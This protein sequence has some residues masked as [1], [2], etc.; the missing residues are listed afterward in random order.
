MAFAM[1][2]IGACPY[3]LKI[4]IP[5][6]ALAEETKD[7]R[8]AIVF[9]DMWDDVCPEFSKSRFQKVILITAADGM[10]SPKRQIVSLIGKIK[11]IRK[12]APKPVGG[13][14]LHLN[15][16]R[17]HAKFYGENVK[18]SFNP[19]RGAFITSSSGTTVGGIVKGTIATNES[20]ISQLMM[21]EASD[22]PYYPGDTCLDPYPPTA[23]TALNLMFLFPLYKGMTVIMDPR[24]SESDFYNQIITHSP[25]VVL[26]TG[27]AWELFFNRIDKELQAG[28]TFDFSFIKGWCIG[29][30]GTDVKKY[31]KW[32]DIICSCGGIGIN[33]GYGCSELFAAASVEKP[34]ARYDLS[35]S[36][37][38]VG[39]PY[40][41]IN[42]GV[43]DKDGNELCY[44][45]RG[46]LWV[47]S[48]SAMKGYYNKPELT[49]RTKVDGWIHTGDLAEIDQNGFVYIYGRMQ[50]AITLSDGQAIYLFDVANKIKEKEYIDDAIVLPVST[51]GIDKQVVAHI[52]WADKPDGTEK[53]QRINDL[54]TM[55]QEYLPKELTVF[56]YA[57]HEG[58]LPY[59]PT[60]LKKDKNKLSKQK[61][62]Y[63]QIVDN[64]L[65]DIHL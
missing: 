21:S 3:F 19:N 8:F 11:A 43:F 10:P 18:V 24:I 47:K 17:Y 40:A 28:K 32:D 42:M 27:S 12:T 25:S 30:E 51:S 6:E 37:M 59:L 9:E 26:T 41:G 50:D 15:Q 2:I 54:N 64:K 5:L 49:A 65:T 33:S 22:A 60:A 20:V 57:E 39:I 53:I 7:S 44:E 55:L 35:K 23:S 63:Y 4:P 52:V 38:S 31:K 1:N 34:D 14:Y 29:G 36:I 48:K 61:I 16:A 58:M 13:K 46:E 45:Q 56:G 62:G